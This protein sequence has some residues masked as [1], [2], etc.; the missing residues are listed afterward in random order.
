MGAKAITKTG[1]SSQYAAYAAIKDYT[2][3]APPTS[4][5]SEGKVYRQFF[6]LTLA[7]QPVG[8]YGLAFLPKGARLCGI[9]YVQSVTFGGTTTLGI[10][11]T[12]LNEDGLATLTGTAADGSAVSLADDAAGATGY[13]RT[14]ATQATTTEL[15]FGRTVATGYG[16]VL[17]KDTA[18]TITVA[19]A[20][21]PASGS[22][23][24]YI[25]YQ[26]VR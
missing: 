24:G 22:V 19:A 25:D 7:S 1:S 9:S 23:V 6:T 4:R 15:T 14:A 3:Y 17:G 16:L 18:L 8:T 2:G 5:D 21:L 10:G 26:I 12:T 11:L 13:F 20:A